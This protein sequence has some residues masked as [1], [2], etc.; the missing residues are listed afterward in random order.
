[1]HRHQL[2]V[3]ICRSFLSFLCASPRAHG[4][5]FCYLAVGSIQARQKKFSE[6]RIKKA[7]SQLF[8]ALLASPQNP[9]PPRPFRIPQ[10]ASTSRLVRSHLPKTEG[11]TER[12]SLGNQFTHTDALHSASILSP[13][14]LRAPYSLQL[15]R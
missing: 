4:P 3:V 5:A 7:I 11:L 2:C 6:L 15:A 14:R 10:S 9:W 8:A 12:R 1:M 13:H